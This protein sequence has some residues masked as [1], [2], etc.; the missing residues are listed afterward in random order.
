MHIRDCAACLALLHAR[1]QESHVLAASLTEDNKSMP[2][3]L[4]GTRGWG[5]PQSFR[6]AVSGHGYSGELSK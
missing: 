6:G 4:L 2:A 1:K 5:V 3:G